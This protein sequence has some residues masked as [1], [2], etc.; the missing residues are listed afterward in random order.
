MCAVAECFVPP[1]GHPYSRAVAKNGN[2]GTRTLSG[3]VIHQAIRRVE[4]AG[5]D[6]AALSKLGGHSLRAGFVTQGNGADGSAIARQTRSRPPR[7]RRG[8]PTR[9]C[10][11][12]G[13]CDRRHR[14][15]DR[16][17]CGIA[18]GATV[19]QRGRD[20]VA[21]N[22][23]LAGRGSAG[24]VGRRANDRLRPGLQ[25]RAVG[26]RTGNVGDQRVQQNVPQEGT[27]E[28]YQR[29]SIGQL[30]IIAMCNRRTLDVYSERAERETTEEAQ[31]R[32][33]LDS[34]SHRHYEDADTR[35][36]SVPSRPLRTHF[37]GV[38]RRCS[39]PG[40]AAQMGDPTDRKRSC[41]SVRR[42]GAAT[43]GCTRRVHHRREYRQR[44][45][46]PLL[47]DLGESQIRRSDPG[48]PPPCRRD[49]RSVHCSQSIRRRR[50][51]RLTTPVDRSGVGDS[52]YTDIR[53]ST[54]R[55]PCPCQP[56]RLWRLASARRPD[57]C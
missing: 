55:F 12:D 57:S 22:A 9:A 31:R 35:S 11:A 23:A 52:S 49:G 40:D 21:G 19:S 32:G 54:R 15:V 47:A 56:M 45:G 25:T 43:Q 38:Y 36:G 8:I 2:L 46:S 26:G 10:I 16:Q 39:E 1:P 50:L 51:L 30:R 53:I 13:K 33:Y 18:F 48:R 42:Q 5:C 37:G 28:S 7:L 17:R 14:L 4:H 41:R 29:S 20:V 6:L 24:V 44:S 27:Q 3:A 34:Q